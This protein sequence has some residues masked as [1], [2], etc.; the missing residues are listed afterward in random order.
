VRHCDELRADLVGNSREEG[1]TRFARR[2][3]DRDLALA[4]DCFDVNMVDGARHAALLSKCANELS[5]GARGFA[6]QTVI[7]MGDDRH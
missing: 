5:I 1:V 7:E 2:H 6:A 4:R 3:F